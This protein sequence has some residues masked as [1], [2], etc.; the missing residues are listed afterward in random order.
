MADIDIITYMACAC[1]QC[2]FMTEENFTNELIERVKFS[3]GVKKHCIHK[4]ARSYMFIIYNNYAIMRHF[5]IGSE[6]TT[7]FSPLESTLLYVYNKY[8]YWLHTLD[9]FCSY[10]NIPLSPSPPISAPNHF[11]PIKT[12]CMEYLSL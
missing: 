9:Q 10:I 7:L 1:I 11:R 4:Q 6:R 8:L 12:R 3:E 5:I 2:F